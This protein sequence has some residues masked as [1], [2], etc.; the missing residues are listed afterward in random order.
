ME[1]AGERL[2]AFDLIGLGGL[3]RVCDIELVLLDDNGPRA[4]VTSHVHGEALFCT[5]KTGF[6]VRGRFMLPLDWCLLG[7]VHRTDDA[8]SWCHGAMLASGSVLTL[9]P[10]GVSE[11]VLSANSWIT[12][13]MVPVK[14]VRQKFNELHLSDRPGHAL[15]LLNPGAAHP[16]RRYYGELQ[17]RMVEGASSMLDLQLDEVMD[18]H[19][20]GILDTG[21][22][23]RAVK[24]RG[25]RGHYMILRK[26]EDFMRMNLRQNI[27]MTEICAAAGVSER[28]LR[29]A[30]D[31]MLGISPNRYLSMLR[32]C[33]ACRSLSS[34]DAGRRSVKAIALSCGLWDLSRFAEN[35]R[36]V[37]GEL[38]R[39]TLMRQSGSA[40]YA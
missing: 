11:F 25:R 26:A 20:R 33:T 35:Y 5:I 17:Q 1:D 34:A 7:Y 18:Q 40:E 4:A 21:P 30:F 9:M 27:Y 28:A 22:L 10:D 6:A 2:G 23:D 13:V 32:L 31:D 19:L 38:P 36:R 16:L 14:R 12:V 15:A 39:D 24:G 3:L 8:V 29:Y 37:F